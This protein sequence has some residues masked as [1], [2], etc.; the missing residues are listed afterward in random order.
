MHIHRT[1]CNIHCFIHPFIHTSVQTVV[2]IISKVAIGEFILGRRRRRLLLASHHIHAY[3]KFADWNAKPTYVSIHTGL[4]PFSQERIAWDHKRWDGKRSER[5]WRWR[6]LR[7]KISE[8]RST[9]LLSEEKRK[10][11]LYTRNIEK[12][13]VIYSDLNNWLLPLLTFNFK[14]LRSI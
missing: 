4:E 6:V 14:I 11:I 12:V 7:K 9:H 5:K 10:D 13:K 3:A 1:A 2:L 8:I